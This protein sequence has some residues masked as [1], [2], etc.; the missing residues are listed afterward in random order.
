MAVDSVLFV[1][2]EEW[3]AD[4]LVRCLPGTHCETTPEKLAAYRGDLS[5]VTAL[6]PF[7]YSPIDKDALDRLP[8]LKLIS[9]R[10]A[11]FDHIDLAECRKRHITVCNIP[12]YG[13]KTVAEHAMALL[14]A[15]SRK[16]PESIERTRK[17]EFDFHTLRGFDL[18]GKT[19]G[20][21]GT[22]R[23]GM[24][25]AKIAKGFDMVVLG[26]DVFPN[27]AAAEKIGLLYVTLDQLFKNSDT[28]SLHLRL[29]DETH[30]FIGEEEFAKM[31]DGVVLINT[32]RGALID[33]R[34]FLAALENGKVKAAGLDVLE[35]ET[36]LKEES[37]LLYRSFSSKKLKTALTSTA[38]M[39]RPNVIVTPHN[40]FNSEEALKR[41]LEITMENIHSFTA[42]HPQNVVTEQ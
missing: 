10:S 33:S 30:H 27:H 26:F 19:L 11:G 2:V 9:T 24:H 20:I 1:E 25:M 16:I 37:E 23:I 34:A 18:A 41:I 4:Y 15:I 14:L 39:K 3:E 22:G 29:T 8:K 6:S 36:L 40:A 28:I 38:L 31:K 7:I 35:E 32:A 5:H 42:G 17:G 13:E 12:G 21:I